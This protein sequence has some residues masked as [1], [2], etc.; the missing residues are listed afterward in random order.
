MHAYK[1]NVENLKKTRKIIPV[2]AVFATG[3]TELVRV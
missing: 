1:I 2:D 3:V